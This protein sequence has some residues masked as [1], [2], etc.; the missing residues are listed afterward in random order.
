VRKTI[1]LP[2]NSLAANDI[3]RAADNTIPTIR[4]LRSLALVAADRGAAKLRHK[5]N[6]AT[7]EGDARGG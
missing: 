2:K 4:V 6:K 1:D 7:G 5:P 3:K